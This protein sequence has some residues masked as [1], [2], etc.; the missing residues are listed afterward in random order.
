MFTRLKC[1]PE[2]PRETEHKGLERDLF[3]LDNYKAVAAQ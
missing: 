2:K 1:E 3:S